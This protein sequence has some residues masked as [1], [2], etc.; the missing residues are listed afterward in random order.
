LSSPKPAYQIIR[1]GVHQI[2]GGMLGKNAQP[3][4]HPLDG[5]ED[6]L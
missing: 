1:N 6:M 2:I 5:E 3:I 4:F